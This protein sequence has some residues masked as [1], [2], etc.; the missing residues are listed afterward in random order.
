VQLPSAAQAIA[1][2]IGAW[3]I[4]FRGGLITWNEDSV[5]TEIKNKKKGLR[6]W[7]ESV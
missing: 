4:D 3:V 2:G 6:A 1:I 5:K 7:T